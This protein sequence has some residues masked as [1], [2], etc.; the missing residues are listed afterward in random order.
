MSFGLLNQSK[1]RRILSIDGGGMRGLFSIKILECVITKL[2]GNNG[3]EAT[4]NFLKNF[5]IIGGTSVGGIISMGLVL[6]FSIGELRKKFYDLGKQVFDNSWVKFPSNIYNY[7]KSGDYYSSKI[8]TDFIETLYGKESMN[9]ITSKVFLI[10]TAA[11]K[12]PYEIYL[13]RSYDNIGSPYEGTKDSTVSNSIKAS[14][15]APTYFEP[16]IDNLGNKYLDGGVIANNP[17]EATIFESFHL[18]P[19]D[20]ISLILSIGTGRPKVETSGSSIISINNSIVN[21]ATNSELTHLRVLE[22]ITEYAK[23]TD[24]IRFSPDN[25]GSIRLDTSNINTLE[26]G[27]IL[28]ERYMRTEEK[29]IEKLKNNLS[30]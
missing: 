5:D 12:D 1:P 7:M 29:Q 22:W 11:T 27:E 25:L 10:A 3:I 9:T 6:G 23:S 14:T 15:A 2:Y 8:L 17:T 20:P 28:T 24:Y 19:D 26:N 30:K 18:M 13:F 16:Y 21:I 4:Q